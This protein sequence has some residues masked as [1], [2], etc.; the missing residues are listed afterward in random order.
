MVTKKRDFDTLFEL[1]RNS[2][3]KVFLPIYRSLDFSPKRIFQT[4]IVL[5]FQLPFKEG[6]C[7][8]LNGDYNLIYTLTIN[9]IRIKNTLEEGIADEILHNRSIE[10]SRVEFS[11]LSEDSYF[12]PNGN[13]DQD[14]ISWLVDSS[15][16]KL[17]SVIQSYLLVTKDIDVYPIALR[18]LDVSVF[19]RIVEVNEWT[20][21]ECLLLLHRNI[22]YV[23]PKLTEEKEIEILN[24]CSLIGEDNPLSASE[25]LMLRAKYNFENGFFVESITNAQSS[26]E[27]LIKVFFKNFLEHEKK[28]EK[29]V[30]D[31]I[32]NIA[33]IKIIKNE[34]NIR[35][36]GKWSIKEFSHPIG[37]WYTIAYCIRNRILHSGYKP[38]FDETQ[39]ALD[40]CTEAVFYCKRLL[41][42]RKKEYPALWS[43]FDPS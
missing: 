18:M 27:S 21:N 32:E 30:I 24:K 9:T 6:R 37:K 22:D 17:N 25:E 16:E 4:F 11:V 20:Y 12:K 34:M 14:E 39:D 2:Y 41:E 33:F 5:P 40:S 13:L 7:I 15:I 10:K 43:L 19:F 35:L 36:G 3:T 8:T 28:T 1:N 42:K 38:T 31:I 26:F 29:E 23:K